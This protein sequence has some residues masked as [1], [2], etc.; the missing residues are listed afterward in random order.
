MTSLK[1]FF[2]LPVLT[3]LAVFYSTAQATSVSVAAHN[4]TVPELDLNIYLTVERGLATFWFSNDSTGDAV[5]ARI[6]F[7]VGLGDLGFQDPVIVGG[8]GVSFGT[9]F[10]GQARFPMGI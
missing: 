1:R 4:A 3:V 10:P 6:Y 2:V 9:S 8:S 7:E 5:A